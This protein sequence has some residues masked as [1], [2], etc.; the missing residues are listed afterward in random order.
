[1]PTEQFGVEPVHLTDRCIAGIFRV[2]DP[3]LIMTFD[4]FH[5]PDASRHAALQSPKRPAFVRQGFRMQ[6]Q[7]NL[8]GALKDELLPHEVEAVLR[9][10]HAGLICH[11]ESAPFQVAFHDQLRSFYCVQVMIQ[12]KKVVIISDICFDDALDLMIELVEKRY[13]VQLVYLRAEPGAAFSERIHP[14]LFFRTLVLRALN[15]LIQVRYEALIPYTFPVHSF[16]L[17]VRRGWEVLLHVQMHAIDRSAGILAVHPLQHLYDATDGHVGA[18]VLLTCDIVR[19][20]RTDQIIIY[21]V[22]AHAPLPCPISEPRRS[23]DALLRPVDLYLR[24]RPYLICASNDIVLQTLTRRQPV[25]I[26]LH[27]PSLIRYSSSAFSCSF[28]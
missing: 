9:L 16:E 3:A 27:R 20:E 7:N 26:E 23:R 4:V 8:A 11:R 12:N 14:D 13:L 22:V 18:L 5:R 24:A 2:S 28:A 19:D 17:I 25:D 6:P 21:A 15:D 10:E 1:M